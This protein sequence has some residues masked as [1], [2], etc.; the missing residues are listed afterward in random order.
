MRIDIHNYEEFILDF[1]EGNLNEQGTEEMK[2][3]LL[4]HPD[5]AEDI[6]DLDE[7]VLEAESHSL[8]END[9]VAQLK[10]EEIKVLASINEENY[11]E[12]LIAELEGDLSLKE[13]NELQQFIAV[14]PQ[15]KKEQDLVQNLK[16]KADE[17]VVFANKS[18]LKK[19]DRA[20]VAL[21]TIA[22]SVAAI[23][24]IS[25]WIF[26]LPSSDGRLPDFEPLQSI[27][28]AS[29]QIDVPAIQIKEKN[30][31]S[32]IATLPLD[33]IEQQVSRTEIES[34][35]SLASIK[36][37]ISIEDQSWKNEML[38]LQAYAFDKKQRDTQVNLADFPATNKSG[39]IKLISSMLWKT[40]KASVKSFSDEL[41]SDE[42]KLFST[43]NIGDLTGGMF[44]IKRPSKEV[45]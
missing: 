23:L 4:M 22:S 1:L 31:E 45:E 12:V 27:E 43:D 29:F 11:E 42:V 3:F 2:A 39:P 8:L 5:I 19:K 20:V 17:K 44:Q 30:E 16:V 10:K 32:I 28:I 6:E 35:T 41:I 21:W 38:L 26:N 13:E 33:I 36:S 34:F 37:Q 14:N 18:K 40:T 25:F 7:F 15:I 9:F 24:L